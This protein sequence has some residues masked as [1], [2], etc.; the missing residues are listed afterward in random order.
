MRRS[1]K[2][3]QYAHMKRRKSANDAAQKFLSLLEIERLD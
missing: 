1:S 2:L 3:A